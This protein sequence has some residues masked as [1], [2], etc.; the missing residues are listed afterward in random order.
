MMD[1]VRFEPHHAREIQG[2]EAATYLAGR[3]PPGVLETY[4][5]API[6]FTALSSTGVPAAAG[7]I[8]PIGDDQGEAWA[9]VGE[10][11]RPLVVPIIR[12]MSHFLDQTTF[13]R[14]QAVVKSDFGPGHRLLKAL[15]FR[16]ESS[17][18]Q[19]LDCAL[20][21]RVRSP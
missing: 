1:I 3:Y 9:I 5:A 8:V 13:R 6:A 17:L 20:Y 12:M 7:G 15:G 4:A 18:I 16:V 10:A 2:V 21:A 14:I 19:D 11:A